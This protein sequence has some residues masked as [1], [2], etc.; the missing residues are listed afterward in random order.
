MK[1]AFDLAVAIF[2]TVSVPA[3]AAASGAPRVFQPV[4]VA[5]EAVEPY[6]RARTR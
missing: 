3:R 6:D 4:I 5:S 2:L 1:H